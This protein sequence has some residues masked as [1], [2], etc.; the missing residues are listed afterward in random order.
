MRSP[1]QL[2]PELVV[3]DSEGSP[4]CRYLSPSPFGKELLYLSAS[5][6]DDRN[7]LA[8]T[9]SRTGHW[10]EAGLQTQRPCDVLFSDGL[11]LELASMPLWLLMQLPGSVSH[12]TTRLVLHDVPFLE[13]G[14]VL[15][16]TV[17]R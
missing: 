6:P 11:D 15:P 7:P 12:D 4:F 10:I 5:T 3:T 16:S 8:P 14:G 17:L 13:Y 9:D 1:E 2:S